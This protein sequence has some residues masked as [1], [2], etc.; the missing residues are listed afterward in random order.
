MKRVLVISDLHCGH[1]T[2]ITPPDYQYRMI[3]NPHTNSDHQHNRFA[4]IQNQVWTWYVESLEQLQP[5]D[6][7]LDVGDNID[8]RG[9]KSGST[10]L[11][12]VNQN[13][14]CSM[15]VMALKLAKAKN[16]FMVYGT[17]YH[18][19]PGYND[20]EDG[21]AESMKAERIESKLFVDINGV[22]FDLRHRASKSSIPHGQGT[23]LAKQKLWN[24][25]WAELEMQPNA[26]IVL[27]GHIHDYSF[28]GR[29]N[30]MAISAPGLEWSTKYGNRI[31]D[32]IINVGLLY[33]DIES[34]DDFIWKHI[35]C[36]LGVLKDEL[37]KV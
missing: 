35:G 37:I 33:F 18:S 11:I 13:R 28:I 25:I 36:N 6:I 17:P 21:I 12:E 24:T 7:L 32:G 3:S 14:Q 34:K 29:Q 16:I 19:A 1:Q 9:E 27:R 20:W 2:G 23:L 8:G 10:E 22:V 15:A 4:E 31:C 5:I 26:D 30:W